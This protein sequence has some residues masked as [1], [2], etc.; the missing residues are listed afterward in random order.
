MKND[1]INS[2]SVFLTENYMFLSSFADRHAV[3]IKIL[4]KKYMFQSFVVCHAVSIEILVKNDILNL[5]SAF[6]AK[7]YIFR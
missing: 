5:K 4:V 3:S 2:E 6:L 1:I 7:H